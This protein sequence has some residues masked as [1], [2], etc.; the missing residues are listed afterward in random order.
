M[1]P[2]LD[3]N[4][5][6]QPPLPG[7]Q[8]ALK[9]LV[10]DEQEIPVKPG[11]LPR[12][13]WMDKAELQVDLAVEHGFCHL[14]NAIE[15]IVEIDDTHV[16]LTSTTVITRSFHQGR[17][18]MASAVFSHVSAQADSEAYSMA[19]FAGD[20]WQSQ[21]GKVTRI[22]ESVDE[23]KVH[24]LEDDEAKSV[25]LKSW[26]SWLKRKDAVKVAIPA[27]SGAIEG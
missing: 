9:K 3:R 17:S 7:T 12:L 25:L 20:A 21:D 22:I 5:T 6:M 16:V 10:L 1:P 8:L 11:S 19:P 18:T 15:A 13:T 4:I 27:S 2:L 24:F 23:Q 26:D 14:V